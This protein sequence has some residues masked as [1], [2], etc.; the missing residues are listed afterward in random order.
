MT[1]AEFLAK[2]TNALGDIPAADCD[3][4]L[5]FFTEQLDDRI[6]EGMTEAEAVESLGSFNDIIAA[7]REEINT[8]NTPTTPPLPNSAKEDRGESN[9]PGPAAS[10]PINARTLLN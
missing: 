5:A 1:K 2:L 6:E 7:L 8:P 10:P 3:A 9:R 4:A